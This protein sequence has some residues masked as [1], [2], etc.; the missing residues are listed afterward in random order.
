MFRTGSKPFAISPDDFAKLA[1]GAMIAAAGA[2]LTY[3]AAAIPGIDFGPY[4]PAV[5]AVAAVLVNLARKF[6]TDTTT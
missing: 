1:K 6:L 2:A 3:V 5:T 4:T